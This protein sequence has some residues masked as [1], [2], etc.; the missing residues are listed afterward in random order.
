[1]NI[2]ASLWMTRAEEQEMSHDRRTRGGV[3][4]EI[5]LEHQTKAINAIA[6]KT[7]VLVRACVCLSFSSQR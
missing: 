7:V 5:V 1:M 6:T 2:K 4:A 3:G